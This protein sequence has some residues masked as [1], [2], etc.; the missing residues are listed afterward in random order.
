VD[1]PETFHDTVGIHIAWPLPAYVSYPAHFCLLLASNENAPLYT[2]RAGIS[3]AFHT[4]PG[5]PLAQLSSDAYNLTIVLW[6]GLWGGWQ[7]A[8]QSIK[9]PIYHSWN[10]HLFAQYDPEA[11]NTGIDWRQPVI[12]WILA[13]K[14]SSKNPLDEWIKKL[15]GE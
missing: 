10:D 1:I 8:P 14:S 5:L 6:F 11:Y 7:T 13:Q 3:S 12:D 4:D 9:L 15:L 2:Q